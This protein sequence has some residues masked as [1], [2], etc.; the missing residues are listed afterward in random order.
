MQ[1]SFIDNKLWM[2]IFKWNK[3]KY[4][5]PT[6]FDNF[7]SSLDLDFFTILLQLSNL[8][9]YLMGCFNTLIV[10]IAI[11]KIHKSQFYTNIWLADCLL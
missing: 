6:L 3:Y 2:I 7:V 9:S 5:H 4:N 11:F 10:F 8:V 1:G